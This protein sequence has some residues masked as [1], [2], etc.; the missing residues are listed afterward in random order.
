M[1]DTIHMNERELELLKYPTGKLEFQAEYS[2]LVIA[3]F[4]ENIEQLPAYLKEILKTVKETD[5]GYRYRPNGWNIRQIVHHIGDSHMNALIRAKLTLTE[6]NPT[7]KPYDENKWAALADTNSA[8]ISISI[9]IIEG[10]HKRLVLLLKSLDHKEYSRTYYHPES[11]R[12][13]TLAQLLNIYSW[14][15]KH[16][17]GQIKVAL[18][19]KF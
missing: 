4:I 16:H 19:K 9:P 6:E 14:H 7:I 2:P 8:D 11:K 10:V 1:K 12:E 3:G 18:N 15:G 13:F 5:L 17:V